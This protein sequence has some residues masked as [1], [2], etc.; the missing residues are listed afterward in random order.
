M[1]KVVMIVTISGARYID[2]LSQDW[3]PYGETLETSKAEAD[4]LIANSQALTPA[5]WAKYRKTRG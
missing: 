2:G 1:P 5:N 3:P 4:D